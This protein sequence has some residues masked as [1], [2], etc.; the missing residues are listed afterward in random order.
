MLVVFVFIDAV[1]DSYLFRTSCL[2]SS[3]ALG[4]WIRFRLDGLGFEAL[5][6]VSLTDLLEAWLLLRSEED[7]CWLRLLMVLFVLWGDVG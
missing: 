7:A 2:T 3:S 1:Y 4:F 6:M 5:L